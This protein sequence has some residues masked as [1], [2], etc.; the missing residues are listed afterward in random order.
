MERAPT[1]G[2]ALERT[3]EAG[4][5]LIVGRVELLVAEV[6][7]SIHEGG[8][9]VLAVV[10]AIA[11]WT[12]LVRGVTDGLSNHYPRHLVEVGVGLVHLGAASAFAARWR[13]R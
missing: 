7:Q 5:S 2:D 10:V 4:Q 9:L 1:I 12:Y 13:L 6:R 11:G 8:L 3:V